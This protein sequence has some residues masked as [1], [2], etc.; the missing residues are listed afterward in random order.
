MAPP[1]SG[2]RR[3]HPP[4]RP[5]FV[6]GEHG[7]R[8]P[9]KSMTWVDP[10]PRHGTRRP[11]HHQ[12]GCFGTVARGH[13]G[14]PAVPLLQQREPNVAGGDD[15][16]RSTGGAK[17]RR[18]LVPNLRSAGTKLRGVAH[19][20]LRLGRYPP[21]LIPH[22]DG[23]RPSFTV[24]TPFVTGT[25]LF[26]DGTGSIYWNAGTDEIRSRPRPELRESLNLIPEKGATGTWNPFPVPQGRGFRGVVGGER[27]CR[28]SL[29]LH[30]FQV[31]WNRPPVCW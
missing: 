15:G 16:G 1:W 17:W 19:A 4:T 14:H 29:T 20:G 22:E 7:G 9:W 24:Q 5:S 25:T 11:R 18:T 13:P 23:H 6:C 31:P 28:C 8:W 26:N 10:L 27:V 21:N 2:T 30:A 12:L 3:W